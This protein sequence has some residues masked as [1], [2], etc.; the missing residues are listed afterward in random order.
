M[1]GGLHPT[2]GVLG[3]LFVSLVSCLG[4]KGRQGDV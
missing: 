2:F 1:E 3:S 4:P